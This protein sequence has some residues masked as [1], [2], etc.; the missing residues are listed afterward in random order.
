[1]SHRFVF[2]LS[3]FLLSFFL[4]VPGRSQEHASNAVAN[5]STADNS[6]MSS[7]ESSAS[8]VPAF[9]PSAPALSAPAASAPVIDTSELPIK[10]WGNS[11]SAKFHRPSC[12]FAK[13]MN[14]RHVVLFH[15]RREAIEAGQMPC[16][17]C[18][19]PFVKRVECVLLPKTPRTDGGGSASAINEV[20]DKEVPRPANSSGK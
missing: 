7:S 10:Y 1:M 19:P 20:A 18:L 17:Y 12:P 15:F 8:Y 14:S 5:Y 6:A 4:C 13:S 16:R 2:R 11:S 9:A 3:V